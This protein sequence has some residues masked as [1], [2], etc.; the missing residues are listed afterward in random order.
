ML[1]AGCK[2]GGMTGIDAADAPGVSDAS[3]CQ[4]PPGVTYIVGEL[5]LAPADPDGD[6]VI[7]S[8]VGL[9]PDAIKA[10]AHAQF[11]EAT[12]TGELIMLMHIT[13]WTDPPTP[14]DPDLSVHIWHAW[15]ADM[16][17]IPE[18]NFSGSGEFLVLDDQFDIACRSRSEADDVDLVGGV[19]TA[20]RSEWDFLLS[21][22]T[23][24][25]VF[26]NV[27]LVSTFDADY[28]HMSSRQ[29]SICTFCS[30]AALP[31]PGDFTGSTLDA[32]INDPAIREVVVPDVDVD[33]DGLETVVGDGVSVLY[34]L[35]G[36]GV[37]RIEGSDCPCHPAIADAYSCDAEYEWVRGYIT[38]VTDN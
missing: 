35:D 8:V 6:G 19:L 38:G 37:T 4:L 23:G 9:L 14:D 26:S 25:V 36:D 28:S 3:F 17:A 13:G 30:L 33:G 22:G 29:D 27:T 24:T 12:L 32:F 5:R 34:C 16:P 15:D 7:D 20:R 2:G 18:N 31:F 11:D 10:Q 21:T 1:A